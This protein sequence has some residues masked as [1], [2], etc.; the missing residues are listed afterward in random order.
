MTASVAMTNYFHS[1][2]QHQDFGSLEIVMDNPRTF[3]PAPEIVAQPDASP[4]ITKAEKRWSQQLDLSSMTPITKAPSI[5]HRRLS[6]DCFDK[7]DDNDETPTP[8]TV[9]QRAPTPKTC[10]RKR[11]S[12]TMAE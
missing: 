5:P 8:P 1:L 3:C 6:M 2:R 12:K 11:K 4:K 7:E 10:R 9:R